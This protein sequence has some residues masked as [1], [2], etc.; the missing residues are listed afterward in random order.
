MEI[1]VYKMSGSKFLLTVGRLDIELEGEYVNDLKVQLEM[2]DWLEGLLGLDA[3]QLDDF[4]EDALVMIT[5][6][7]VE[8]TPREKGLA[9]QFMK[10]EYTKATLGNILRIGMKADIE[11]TRKITNNY[12]K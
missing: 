12:I 7:K 5:E 3:E 9:T 11:A 6:K 1:D 2:T 8:L 10:G 4:R